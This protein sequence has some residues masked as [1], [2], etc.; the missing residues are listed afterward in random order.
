MDEL[1]L[2]YM[3]LEVFNSVKLEDLWDRYNDTYLT[4]VE[5][6]GDMDGDYAYYNAKT[7]EVTIDKKYMEKPNE[8]A[9]IMLYMLYSYMS[10][11]DTTLSKTTD[12]YGIKYADMVHKDNDKK[13]PKMF[14]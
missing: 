4:V 8:L 3:R 12:D 2:F 7:R 11:K 10:G 9:Y 14:R 6:S 1:E 5:Y 13:I